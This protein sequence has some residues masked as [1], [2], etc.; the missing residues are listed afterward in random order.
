MPDTTIHYKFVNV[1]KAIKNSKRYKSHN[2][3]MDIDIIKVFKSS[4][5]STK[6][7]HVKV[8]GT[9]DNPLFYAEQIGSLLGVANIYV[10]IKDFDEFE[11]C[12]GY[13]NDKPITFLTKR[14]M[15]L[16]FDQS[17]KT[18]AAVLIKW[19]TRTIKELNQQK[20][21][22]QIDQMVHDDKV[23]YSQQRLED[24]YQ[25]TQS[26]NKGLMYVFNADYMDQ[27]TYKQ[28][29]VTSD[30]LYTLLE[31]FK[32]KHPYGRCEYYSVIPLANMHSAMLFLQD[33]ISCNGHHLN[34]IQIPSE[35]ARYW[36]NLI[37][38]MYRIGEISNPEERLQKM[39]YIDQ[40][41]DH[42]LSGA[43]QPI[44]NKLVFDQKNQNKSTE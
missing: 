33:T 22:D 20:M 35:M 8:R 10:L 34:A 9:Y 6:I 17:K 23:F 29:G 5:Y 13:I 42:I 15:F 25:N 19:L 1:S 27:N 40:A 28:I 24:L 18:I 44:A 4:E 43:P 7:N 39:M 30:C 26:Q 16:L 2:H 32:K 36:V 41:C 12:V 14:G 38:N 3:Q 11:K 31:E 21:C 37:C